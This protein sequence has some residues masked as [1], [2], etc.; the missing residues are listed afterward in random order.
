MEQPCHEF[1]LYETCHNLITESRRVRLDLDQA[2]GRYVNARLRTN[3]YCFSLLNEASARFA[4]LEQIR[5]ER[6]HR[7]LEEMF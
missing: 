3:G 1:D 5:A 6:A 4:A 2:W 7:A